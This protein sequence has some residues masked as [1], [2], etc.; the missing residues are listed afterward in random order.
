LARRLLTS[1]LSASG[2]ERTLPFLVVEG[3]RNADGWFDYRMRC[4]VRAVLI[5]LPLLMC[6][7]ESALIFECW[8]IYK[9]C[10]YPLASESGITLW[11]YF[12]GTLWERPREGERFP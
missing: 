4:R 12:T 2:Y 11:L 7:L 10:S 9:I 6:C 8:W 1:R 5:I 3:G